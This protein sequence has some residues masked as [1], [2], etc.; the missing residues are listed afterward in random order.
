MEIGA[1]LT[2]VIF[3]G[4]GLARRLAVPEHRKRHRASEDPIPADARIEALE[5]QVAAQE[6]VIAELRAGLDRE[7]ALRRAAIARLEGTIV[8]LSTARS[9]KPTP[10]RAK[11]TYS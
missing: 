9:P 11:A 8:E 4:F 6:A 7:I 10:I 1:L 3:A 5:R 2:T